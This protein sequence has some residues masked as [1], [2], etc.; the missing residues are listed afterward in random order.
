M[1]TLLT[2]RQG[3]YTEATVFA[4]IYL[5]SFSLECL[6]GDPTLWHLKTIIVLNL[7]VSSIEILGVTTWAFSMIPQR[8]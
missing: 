7:T 8:D 6:V 5:I 2:L 1:F 4:A 3:Y